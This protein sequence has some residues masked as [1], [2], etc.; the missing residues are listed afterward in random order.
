MDGDQLMRSAALYRK[1]FGRQNVAGCFLVIAALLHRIV[2]TL[3]GFVGAYSPTAGLQS[4]RVCT[5]AELAVAGQRRAAL[6]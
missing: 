3:P 2:D 5:F 1:V 6:I 4:G